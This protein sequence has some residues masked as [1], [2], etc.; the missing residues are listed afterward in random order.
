MK[1]QFSTLFSLTLCVSSSVFAQ[2]HEHQLD[3]Q[4]MRLGEQVEYCVTHK[5]MNQLLANP[6][7]A[8]QY[9][10]DQQDF[11]HALLS[12]KGEGTTKAIEY[13]I[14]VVFHVLHNGG[15]ENISKD[16]LMSALT[17]LNRDYAM[18]NADTIGVQAAFQ[19]I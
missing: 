17:I 12:K 6:E 9:A 1:K 15:P 14:P 11:D 2:N 10:K 5:K 3:K 7:F 8:K 13:T 18:L 4:N 16:Q 19:G